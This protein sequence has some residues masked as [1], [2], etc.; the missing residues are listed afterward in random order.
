VVEKVVVE[1]SGADEPGDGPADE[2]GGGPGGGPDAPLVHRRGR[3]LR[4]G[5]A[6]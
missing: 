1:S 4:P 6:G 2:P 5:R 3:Y